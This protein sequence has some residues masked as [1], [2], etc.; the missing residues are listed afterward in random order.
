MEAAARAV[1]QLFEQQPE[2]KITT[3]YDVIRPHVLKHRET[4]QVFSYLEKQGFLWNPDGDRY[5]P[6]IPSLMDYV[7]AQ[8]ALTSV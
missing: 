5:V 3:L 8:R 2:V 1:V 6:G 4:G 7:L